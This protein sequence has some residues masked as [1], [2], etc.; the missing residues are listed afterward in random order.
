MDYTDLPLT[1]FRSGTDAEILCFALERVHKQF[2]WKT[3]GLNADQLRRQHPPSSMTIAGLIK[4]MAFVED[5]FTAMAHDRPLGP[6]WNI[7]DWVANDQWG[8]NSA[9]TDDPAQLYALW[10]AAVDRSRT[11]WAEMINDDGGLDITVAWGGNNDEQVS[12]RRILVD[13]LEENLK[14]TGHADVLREAIDGLTG[15]DPPMVGQPT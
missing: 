1:D 5:G 12:R 13:L 3:G 4:H 6:P 10:Y 2:A 8:W 11:A 14:H 9:V 15:N 7:R